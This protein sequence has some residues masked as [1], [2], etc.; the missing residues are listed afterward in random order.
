[1]LRDLIAELD[2][3]ANTLQ[4]RGFNRLAGRTDIISN[5]LESLDK[6]VASRKADLGFPKGNTNVKAPP[7]SE[8]A[9]EAGHSD[10]F[11]AENYHRVPVGN[12]SVSRMLGTPSVADM[13]S[14]LDF[15]DEGTINVQ[16]S[17]SRR[18]AEKTEVFDEGN[19]LDPWTTA[20][21]PESGDEEQETPPDV[22]QKGDVLP[23]LGTLEEGDLHMPEGSSSGSESEINKIL[24][25]AEEG[26]VKVEPGLMGRESS[27][28]Q[29]ILAAYAGRQASDVEVADPKKLLN[30]K[31]DP[32]E[33]VMTNFPWVDGETDAEPVVGNAKTPQTLGVQARR[34][35]R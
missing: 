13:L 8:D 5:T 17:R 26:D 1:M 29:R 20:G 30:H 34:K 6:R 22:D 3:I 19:A 31:G 18:K 35:S 27:R 33:D 2:D 11:I 4:G 15:A 23:F 10:Q 24:T 14:R 9:D 7:G 28:A 25:Q 32:L 16:S 12:D 21:L